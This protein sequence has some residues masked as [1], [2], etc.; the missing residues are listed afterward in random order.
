MER[1]EKAKGDYALLEKVLSYVP[2]YK[3]YKE[4]EVRR[5][6]DRLVRMQAS[7]RIKEAL[8]KLRRSLALVAPRMGEDDRGLAERVLTRLDTVKERTERAVA[9]YAGFFD[10][11]KVGEERLNKLLEYDVGLLN[12]AEELRSLSERFTSARTSP[13]ELRANLGQMLSAIEEYDSLLQ[14]RVELIRSQ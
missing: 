7:S 3:G 10:V 14:G 1:V 6:T 4:K 5:E 11:V 12:K 8:D 9:G 13:E 2:G